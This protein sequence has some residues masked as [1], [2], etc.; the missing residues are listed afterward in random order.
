MISVSELEI[1]YIVVYFNEDGMGTFSTDDIVDSS[2]EKPTFVAAADLD[3]D[4]DMDLLATAKICGQ[5]T[6]YE[7]DGTGIFSSGILIGTDDGVNHAFAAD[8]DGE[9]DLDVA[10]AT[11]YDDHIMWFENLLNETTS[12]ASFAPTLSP[13]SPTPSSAPTSSLLPPSPTDPTGEGL[14]HI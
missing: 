14:T 6:W 10:S 5:I 11:W 2:L 12:N 3:G 7:N 1:G 4:G 9:G 8:L 13:L